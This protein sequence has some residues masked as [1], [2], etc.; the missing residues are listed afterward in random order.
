MIGR[1]CHHHNLHKLV[2]VILLYETLWS[3]Y[4]GY[5]D[6][7]KLNEWGF[8][9]PLCT[10]RQTWAM[11]T[12]WVWWYERDDT[13]LQTHD[14]KF[15]PWRSESKHA[16]SWSRRFP[17]ILNPYEWMGKKH[18]FFFK[19]EAHSGVR[20]RDLLLL[21]KQAVLTTTP[22]PP[23]YSPESQDKIWFFIQHSRQKC[24]GT[25]FYKDMNI[26]M[27]KVSPCG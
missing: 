25:F 3:N 23:S 5:Y 21:F 22:G 10:Y 6:P 4:T 1:N 12:S 27:I 2:Y 14:S 18:F 26:N 13:A 20:T 16:T 8:M 17:T 11:R 24:A 9:P 19:L 7:E 15:K